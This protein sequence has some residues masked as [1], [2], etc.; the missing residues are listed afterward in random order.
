MQSAVRDGYQDNSTRSTNN[1]LLTLLIDQL[2][3]FHDVEYSMGEREGSAVLQLLRDRGG[4]VAECNPPSSGA[5]IT[6]HC[7][8]RL[9]STSHMLV[10][11]VPT[12]HSDLLVL[13]PILYRTADKMASKSSNLDS[14]IVETAEGVEESEQPPSAAEFVEKPAAANGEAVATQLETN[15][16]S[17]TFSYSQANEL[18]MPVEEE[19]K[20]VADS[21]KSTRAGV[22]EERS[23]RLK[24]KDDALMLP[25]FV[26]DCQLSVI[27]DQVASA[28]MRRMPEDIIEDFTFQ[29]LFFYYHSYNWFEH[30]RSAE[31]IH[32]VE[33]LRPFI[34]QF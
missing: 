6:W 3:Q 16:V 28:K 30:F 11:L 24:A 34:A 17:S 32:Y 23:E 19:A 33:S 20:I 22:T 27:A 21:S 8:I 5:E 15:D 14:V 9:L 4:H 18:K 2:R 10:S 12:N 25:I 29:V 26:F 1:L 31:V 13:S 7:F